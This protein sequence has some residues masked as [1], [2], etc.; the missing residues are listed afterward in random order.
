MFCILIRVPRRGWRLWRIYWESEEARAL[1]DLYDLRMG[2]TRARLTRLD[3]ARP[4]GHL[5]A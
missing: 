5:H 3:D 1:D 2:G 4:R